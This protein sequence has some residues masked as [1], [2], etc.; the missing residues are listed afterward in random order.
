MLWK[1]FTVGL[2]GIKGD[3]WFSKK[4]KAEQYIGVVADRERRK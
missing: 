1:N 3:V 2:T 4:H